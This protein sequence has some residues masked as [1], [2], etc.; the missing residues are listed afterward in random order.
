MTE[1]SR[2]SGIVPD[3]PKSS[4]FLRQI[5]ERGRAG[6]L[7]LAAAYCDSLMVRTGRTTMDRDELEV[8]EKAAAAGFPAAV[9][10]LLTHHSSAGNTRT[11]EY[12]AGLCDSL[13]GLRCASEISQHYFVRSNEG[14]EDSSRNGAAMPAPSDAKMANEVIGG[15]VIANPSAEPMNGAEHGLATTTASTPVKKLPP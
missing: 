2:A 15:C 10:G 7:G 14:T 12:F 9:R 6:E 8:C 3:E 1:P 11:A 13:L 4:N 5:I